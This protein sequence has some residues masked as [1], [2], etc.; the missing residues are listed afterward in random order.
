M[1]FAG[2]VPEGST[3]KL[4]KANVD[5]LIEG[6]E[7]A[8]ELARTAPQT[9]T[10]PTV[11]IAIS[12]IGRR[13]VLGESTEDEIEATLSLL[14]TNTVQ[15]G[16]YSYGEVSPYVDGKAYLHNQTMTLTTLTEHTT[17]G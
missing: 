12:C 14:P 10:S 13:L 3:V 9:D 17:N 8:T 2:D 7:D 15:I 16:F 6:A 11:A 1:T 4:M 5:R